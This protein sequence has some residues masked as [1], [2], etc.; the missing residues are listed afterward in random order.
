V[1]QLAIV[2]LVVFLVVTLFIRI[3]VAVRQTGSTG[4][5]GL[6]EGAGALEVAS[7]VVFVAGNLVGASS[8]VLVLSD[9]ID[10]ISS[11]DTAAAHV[12][13][14][15]LAA[16]GIAIVFA[17]QMGMGSSWRIGVSDEQ[18]TDLVTGGLFRL[19]R[20][21]IYA[22]MFVTWI[23]FFGMVP[24]IPAIV[25][26]AMVVIALEGQVRFVEEP[27]MRRTHGSAYQNY[28]RRVGRFVPGVGRA[29]R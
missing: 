24:T 21:P 22:A 25:G 3:A 15:I 19:S 23:G 9:V 11:I 8:P 17:A 13:G 16:G 27:F 4:L 5:L 12:A 7:G 28:E 20:N 2:L 29:S 26:G 1:P 18:D 14:V 6:R 10:P